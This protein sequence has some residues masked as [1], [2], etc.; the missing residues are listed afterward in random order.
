MVGLPIF[1]DF[2]EEGGAKG[3]NGDAGEGFPKGHN[4]EVA[5][6]GGCV[7]GAG[8]CS[9]L[10]VM[11]V[12]R[13]L[14]RHFVLWRYASSEQLGMAGARGVLLQNRLCFRRAVVGQDAVGEHVR[15]GQIARPGEYFD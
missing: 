10:T 7:R 1:G 3:Q 9:D 8:R 2:V 6:S 11:P 15:V 12:V 13:C 14:G 5:K 4:S